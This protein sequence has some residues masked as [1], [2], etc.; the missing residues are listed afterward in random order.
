MIKLRNKDI[1][2]LSTILQIPQYAIE[3]MAVMNLIHE[4]IAID[5]TT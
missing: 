3:K 5:I 1:E 4:A 2:K